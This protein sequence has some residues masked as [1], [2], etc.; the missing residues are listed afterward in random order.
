MIRFISLAVLLASLSLAPSS[1]DLLPGQAPASGNPILPG[2]F[3]DPVF[4]THE[5][6]HYIY[7]TLDPWG[8]RTLGC[9]ESDDC[10]NWTYRVLNWPTKEACASPES[11]PAA[12]WAPSVVQ[13]PDGRFFMAVSV[14]SEIWVGHADHPLGPWK[15]ALGGRPLVSRNYKPGFHMIDAELFVDDDDAVYMYWGSGLNW[16]NGRCWVVRL[17]DDFASFAEEP[18][19]VTPTHFFEAPFMAK[20]HGKYFLMYSDG[21]T[22]KDTYQI[23]Y[24]VADSPY[25]PFTKPT[26]SPILVTDHA[27]RIVSPG[28]HGIMQ[29]DGRDYILYHRHSIPFDDRAFQRQVCVDELVFTADGRIEK[30]AP[31]H[32][33]PAFVQRREE[34]RSLAFRAPATA[35]SQANAQ[36]SPSFAVD[37]NYAT[38]WAPAP[39]ASDAWLQ[40]DLGEP[41]HFSRLSIRPEFAWKPLRFR[42]EISVDGESWSVLADFTE[43][44]A[45]GSPIVI[46]KTG[47]ARFFRLAF[48]EIGPGSTVGILDWSVF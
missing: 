19:D 39:D 22:T 31:T 18:R 11:G 41:R 37:A 12:V 25:G 26:N 48:P 6:K 32:A 1:A 44:P 40:I 5:G 20:R 10:T 4:V 13:A 33:G 8:D 28:H 42:A 16:V 30:V 2:Y 35:S 38:R 29:R 23:H 45:E 15:D 34:T 9:W 36:T 46:E 14:G 47:A 27:L 24:A 17:G 7:A 21:N 43:V 3:A